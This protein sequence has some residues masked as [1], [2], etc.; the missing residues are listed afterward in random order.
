MGITTKTVETCTCDLCGAVCDKHDGN[1]FI[2]V[3]P[4]DGR[5]VGPGHVMAELRVHIPYKASNGIACRAC[6]IKWL[7][8]YVADQQGKEGEA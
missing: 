3:Y 6:K 5:D 8:K 2:E 4:G 7:S 1:I